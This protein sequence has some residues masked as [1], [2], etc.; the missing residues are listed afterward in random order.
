MDRLIDEIVKVNVLDAVAA[1]SATS[2]NT[3]AFFSE[4]DDDIVKVI[5]SQSEAPDGFTAAAQSFFLERNP[6]KLVCIGADPASTSLTKDEVIAALEGALEMGKDSQ[7]REIDFYHV[8]MNVGESAPTGLLDAL[9]TWC[10]TNFKLGHVE[11]TSRSAAKSALSAMTVPTKRVAVYYHNET[12]GR[13]LALSL[14][15][16]RCAGDPARGTW[17]HKTLNSVAP[18]ATSKS[19][20]TDAQEAGLNVYCKVAGVNRTFF[21]TL[22]SNKLF[23]DSQIKKDWLKFRVQEAVFNLLGQANGGDGADYGDAGIAGVQAAIN[24]IFTQAAGTD[25]MYVLPD[26]FEVNVPKFADIA[27]DQKEVRNLPMVSA[28]FSIQESIHTVKTI[29]LQVV[30]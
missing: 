4:A 19:D 23:I 17:A 27:A 16:N 5:T 1:A 12:S 21:G 6:G 25:R 14:C 24:T 18:D 20:F 11:F 26:S 15:A 10:E 29:E 8:V 3:V 9:E 30:A 2:V 22:G 7:G 13:T 28:T